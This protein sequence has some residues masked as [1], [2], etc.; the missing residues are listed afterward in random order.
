V[1]EKVLNHE[2][3]GMMRIYNQHDYMD[4]RRTALDK[5]SKKL[6]QLI[7]GK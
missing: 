4:E 5:W 7:K 3:T 2:L 1:V 6:K